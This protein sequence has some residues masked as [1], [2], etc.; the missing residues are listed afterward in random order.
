MVFV[1]LLINAS[2]Y[3]GHR[4]GF[5]STTECKSPPRLIHFHLSLV[6]IQLLSV[7]LPS[8]F[9]FFAGSGSGTKTVIS[10]LWA[11]TDQSFSLFAWCTSNNIFHLAP[12]SH[13]SQTFPVFGLVSHSDRGAMPKLIGRTRVEVTIHERPSYG[14]FRVFH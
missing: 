12:T 5:R 11:H 10:L 3:S 1:C 4:M 2:S 8:F 6:D 13:I 14:Q 7:F 9:F